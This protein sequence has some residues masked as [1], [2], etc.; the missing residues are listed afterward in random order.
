MSG[1][2][3]KSGDTMTGTLTVSKVVGYSEKDWQNAQFLSR[4]RNDQNEASRA[5]YGFENI[6]K[7]AALLYLEAGANRLKVKFNN[8]ESKTLAFTDDITS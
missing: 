5:G 1:K 4:S 3:S 2:V 6:N 8:G 7:N